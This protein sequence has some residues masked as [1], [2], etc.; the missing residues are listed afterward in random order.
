VGRGEGHLSGT[1][2]APDCGYENEAF[3]MKP[4]FYAAEAV[5][6]NLEIRI[7]RNSD[8][9]RFTDGLT[10]FVKDATRVR[11]E[12]L[13][14]T[15]QIGESFMMPIKMGIYLNLTCKIDFKGAP[16]AMKAVEGQITFNEIYAPQVSKEDVEISGNWSARFVDNEREPK[17]SAMLGGDFSFLYARGRPAQSFP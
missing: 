17:N 14:T 3:D 1:L 7:Q 8:T 16:S 6:N 9:P 4:S 11:Q 15:L 13:G 12:L 5:E 10:I 2:T